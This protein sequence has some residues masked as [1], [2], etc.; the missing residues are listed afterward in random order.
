MSYGYKPSR[1]LIWALLWI[2]LGSVL[3]AL[4]DSMRIMIPI[5]VEGYAAD[6]K[7]V[8]PLSFYPTFIPWMYSLDT[9]IPIINFGQKEYWVPRATCNYVKVTSGCIQ[10]I[11]GLYLYRWVHTIVG[12]MLITLGVA[13]FTGLVRKD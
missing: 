2:A 5:K 8:Q 13:G 11:E 1:M 4:G 10:G 3:F 7:T 9:F 6:K 12:W